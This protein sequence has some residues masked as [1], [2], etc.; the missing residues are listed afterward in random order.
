[1]SRD[2]EKTVQLHIKV[3]PYAVADHRKS[4]LQIFNTI[5][6][7]LLTWVLAYLLMPVSVFLSIALAVLASGLIV[8]TFIIFHDCTHGSFYHNK[9]LNDTLGTITGVL[10]TFPYDK[11]KREHSIHHASSSNLDERGTGDIW[12]MTVDEYREASRWQ[13]FAYRAYRNPF[14]M[15]GLGPLYLVL[16]SNRKNR[17]DA[18]PKERWN[19]HLIN[20]IMIALTDGLI[21]LVGW[22]AFFIVPGV[23]L[24]IAAL[25]G[26]WLFYI[27]HTFEDSYFEEEEKWNYVKAAVEG[28]SYYQLPKFLQWL[29]GNIG[30]HHVHHLAPRIPNYHLE[31]AHDNTPD[32]K[33][34]TTITLATSLG[35]LKYRLYDPDN[36]RFVTFKQYRA[37]ERHRLY[38][39]KLRNRHRISQTR[40]Q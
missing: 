3:R 17:S 6:P 23:S 24:Y 29:T 16:I 39:K 27:Q 21:Y 38:E 26:I 14:V 25:L 2:R 1:M 33:Y 10:T 19:T 9:K 37:Q 4:T 18:K 22:Q 8:R 15:F 34:A 31:D 35:S 20:I 5:I 13:K 7:L 32:L 40:V 28:S 12:M 11:W 30:F 36:N